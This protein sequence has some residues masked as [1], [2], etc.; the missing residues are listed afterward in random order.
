MTEN[1]NALFLILIAVAL[2]AALSYA[3]T[4]SGRGGGGIDREKAEISA[5]RI[6][7]F[8]GQLEN[9]IQKL[10][11]INGCSDTELNFD[12][13]VYAGYTNG[14]LDSPCSLFHS[15]GG[16]LSMPDF[17]QELGYGNE[18]GLTYI[19]GSNE[20]TGIGTT[21]SA[22]SCSDLVVL[23]RLLAANPASLV[24][25]N[26][27]NSRFGIVSSSPPEDAN[28]HVGTLFTGTYSASSNIQDTGN[29]LLG[30]R[31]GCLR[32][33]PAGNYFVYHVL[34]AR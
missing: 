17:R 21:C 1:G 5:A 2:F 13:G 14:S 11:I 9:T 32:E 20:V 33:G 18:I 10:Q 6:I 4:T 26:G 31:T 30:Q 8:A 28:I 24:I 16:G 7:Q 22:P 34:K 15:S 19:S 12:N 27:V 3:I 29:F 23:I 25:C